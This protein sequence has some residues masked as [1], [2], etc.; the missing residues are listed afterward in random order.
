[1]FFS[2]SSEMQS[3]RFDPELPFEQVC[4]LDLV[5]Y[6]LLALRKHHYKEVRN[7][8]NLLGNPLEKVDYIEL[9]D[10]LGIDEDKALRLSLLRIKNTK[11]EDLP[12]EK[13][14]QKMVES[15]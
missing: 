3:D 4:N 10:F 7:L 15:N 13:E 1:M 5:G 14:E 12:E 6:E 2:T 8:A 11:Y 9:D